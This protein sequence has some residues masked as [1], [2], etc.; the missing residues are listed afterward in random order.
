MTMINEISSFMYLFSTHSQRVYTGI[1]DNLD[2]YN[3]L[4]NKSKIT[5]LLC[6]KYLIAHKRFENNIHS[7]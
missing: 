4:N 1:K 7:F 3:N 2:S 5:I 6:I